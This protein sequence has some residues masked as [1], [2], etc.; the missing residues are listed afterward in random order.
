MQKV[1]IQFNVLRQVVG[2]TQLGHFAILLKTPS[3]R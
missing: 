1:L 2:V 3:Q